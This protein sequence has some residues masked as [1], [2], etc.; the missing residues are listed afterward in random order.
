MTSL[1]KGSNSLLST[2]PLPV[3]SSLSMT[4]FC[5][6]SVNSFPRPRYA[7]I[8]L[9]RPSISFGSRR[10]LSSASAFRNMRSL[11]AANFS[12]LPRMALTDSIRSLQ[13]SCSVLARTSCMRP[14][15]TGLRS[16]S[17][18]FFFFFFVVAS[19]RSACMASIA[20]FMEGLIPTVFCS[21]AVMFLNSLLSTKPFLSRSASLKSSCVMPFKVS[22]TILWIWSMTETASLS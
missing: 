16:A 17:L 8:S 20:G 15:T 7:P 4:I 12:L 14:L 10:P 22:C 3:L 13:S 6:F 5:D 9:S 1:S 18:S 21:M 2:L 11:A 19:S